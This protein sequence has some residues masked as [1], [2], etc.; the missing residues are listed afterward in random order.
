[1]NSIE[2]EKIRNILTNQDKK[3]K[4][5]LEELNNLIN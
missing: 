4:F 5:T 3:S 2:K 1:M